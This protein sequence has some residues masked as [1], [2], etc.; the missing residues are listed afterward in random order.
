M[1]INVRPAFEALAGTWAAWRVKH[2]WF[3]R[4][5]FADLL[6]GALPTKHLVWL[7]SL[8]K[9]CLRAFGSN[10]VCSPHDARPQS[11]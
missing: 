2:L 4:F 11:D 9:V 5:Q 7:T 10:Y 8:L 6:G 3:I 1:F